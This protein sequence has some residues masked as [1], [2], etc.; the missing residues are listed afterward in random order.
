[1]YRRKRVDDFDRLQAHR[2]H[3]PNQTHN[4][5]LVV[6]GRAADLDEITIL[7]SLAS[8]FKDGRVP[9]LR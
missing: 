3:L 6:P 8:K 4:V 2:H 5:L 7:A 9:Y 1:M